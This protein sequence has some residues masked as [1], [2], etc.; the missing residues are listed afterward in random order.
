MQTRGSAGGG[1]I[2]ATA[3]ELL[4]RH[5]PKVFSRGMSVALLRSL[6]VNCTVFPIYG[7]VLSLF[8]ARVMHS[9]G[10]GTRVVKS[11][12]WGFVCT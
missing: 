4:Q 8:I 11:D 9:K 2:L 12:R 1:G 5:G 10:G 3:R 6:P 7:E